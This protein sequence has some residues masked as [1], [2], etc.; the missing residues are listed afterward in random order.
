[1]KV[2]KYSIH[3]IILQRD[4]LGYKGKMYVFNENLSF[5]ATWTH[6][7]GIMLSEISLTEKDKD[8]DITCMW[9]LKKYT[10]VNKT[11]IEADHR[12]REQT[13]TVGRGKEEG[14][15]G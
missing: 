6:L 2:H 7:E 3:D 9:N 13:V 14:K 8:Y 11:K 15:M 4:K 10:V 12:H 1:M 5:A